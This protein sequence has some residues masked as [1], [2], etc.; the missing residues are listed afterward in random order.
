MKNI[1]GYTEH[2]MESAE[3]PERLGRRIIS[4]L[5]NRR[6]SLAKM[7]EEVRRLIE[8]GADV[9]VKK[10][11]SDWT[12]LHYASRDGSTGI[13]RM[14][15]DAGADVNAK[16]DQGNAPLHLASKH[17][18][19]TAV[20]I[21]SGA[22]VNEK[23]NDGWTPLHFMALWGT[24][25]TIGQLIEAGADLEAKNKKGM[26][27]LERIMSSNPYLHSKELPKK[28]ILAGADPSRAFD[29]IDDLKEFFEGDIS[30][31]PEEAMER[32]RKKARSRG[33]FGRF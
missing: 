16:N 23:S 14:L 21:S 29:S 32:I 31:V 3:S 25:E 11:D 7:E 26:T 12:S 1:R 8:A 19:A 30:W 27:P 2:I 22:N 15:I 20:L 5:S 9:R 18:T 28:L 10:K 24:A 13:M 33:A 6:F 4:M 17:P